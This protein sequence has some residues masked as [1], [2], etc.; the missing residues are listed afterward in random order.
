MFRVALQS[1]CLPGIGLDLVALGS[2]PICGC[3][4]AG[5]FL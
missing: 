2:G 4:P 5:I 1:C 3:T